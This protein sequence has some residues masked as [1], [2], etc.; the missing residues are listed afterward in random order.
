MFPNQ[1]SEFPFVVS[2]NKNSIN[3]IDL[4]NRHIQPLIE[5]R[6]AELFCEKITLSRVDNLIKLMYVTWHNDRT[7]VKEI[8]LPDEFMDT[9]RSAADL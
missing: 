1:L 8:T 4:N 5:I 6:N 3:L 2:R 9:L 7:F